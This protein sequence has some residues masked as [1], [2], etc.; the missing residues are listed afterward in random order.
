MEATISEAAGSGGI[1]GF[2]LKAIDPIF[3]KKGAG[4]LVPIKVRGTRDK[5]EF[6]LDVGRVFR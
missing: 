2:L 1:K 4:A 3:R 6:G 5:P